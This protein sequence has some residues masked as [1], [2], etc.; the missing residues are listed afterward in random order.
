MLVAF[1][2]AASSLQD[3]CGFRLGSL[4]RETLHSADNSDN[5][6]T[7]LCRSVLLST[8]LPPKNSD[9]RGKPTQQRVHSHMVSS[10][11]WLTIP[12]KLSAVLKLA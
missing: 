1:V 9:Y 3:F 6:Y 7:R 11:V 10:S 4:K 12:V 5:N 2:S 8:H